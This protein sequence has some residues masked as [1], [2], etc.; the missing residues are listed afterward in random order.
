MTSGVPYAEVI[1]DPVGH[2]KSP[3]I[4]GF[5]LEKLGLAGDYRATRVERGDLAAFL[6]ER[7]RDPLWRGCNVTMPLKEAALPL[8]TRVS[9]EA[10]LVRATNCLVPAG[11]GELLAH[12]TDVDGFREALRSGGALQEPCA[13]HVATLFSLIGTGG[14]ARAALAELKGAEVTVFG[15]DEAKAAALSDEFGPGSEIGF[16]S[17]LDALMAA[18]S[19]FDPAFPDCKPNR[20]EHQRYDH[21]VVNAT[22]LGMR[23][24]PPLPIRLDRYPANT[25]VI[26]MVYD[27]LDTDLLKEARRLGMIA[28]DGLVMLIGQAARAFELF[29]G[30]PAPRQHDSELRALLTA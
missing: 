2:S 16:A 8:A 9:E 27:P 20:G 24:C 17:P 5:W 4:H 6:A 3:L 18:P 12:N 23:G 19:T 29:Y 22:S 30:R 1:G 10:R 13:G 11:G 21:V 28:V 15:R 25:V 7:R 26:D 14:A